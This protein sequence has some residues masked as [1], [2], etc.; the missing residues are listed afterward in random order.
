M[1]GTDTWLRLEIGIARNLRRTQT[2]TLEGFSPKQKTRRSLILH[3]AHTLLPEA[4]VEDLPSIA[5]AEIKAGLNGP[6]RQAI[7]E[8]DKRAEEKL[9]KLRDQLIERMSGRFDWVGALMLA[10]QIHLRRLVRRDVPAIVAIECVLWYGAYRGTKR[11]NVDLVS[12]LRDLDEDWLKNPK[13]RL[14]TEQKMRQEAI[15]LVGNHPTDL[16]DTII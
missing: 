11:P 2:T 9:E 16:I 1:K 12:S 10:D 13:R 14:N 5:R 6:L 7:A 4:D 15:S 3:A 8:A